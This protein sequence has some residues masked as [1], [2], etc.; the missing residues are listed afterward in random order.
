MPN[1]RIIPAGGRSSRGRSWRSGS[2]CSGM[3]VLSCGR[4][5]STGKGGDSIGKG[6]RIRL[7]S[8]PETKSSASLGHAWIREKME[9]VEWFS[10]SGKGTEI[11]EERGWGLYRGIG[12][13]E[14]AG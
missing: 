10:A 4:G 14:R 9:R 2:S 7:H 5:A 12:E 8:G 6:R 1:P 3:S 13:G 11:N